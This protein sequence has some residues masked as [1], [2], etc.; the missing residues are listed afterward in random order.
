MSYS[1]GGHEEKAIAHMPPEVPAALVEKA[2]LGDMQGS[3]RVM[4]PWLKGL[5][6]GVWVVRRCCAKGNCFQSKRSG[7]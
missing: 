6:R 3:G 7:V 2:A 5:G 4:I 1:G